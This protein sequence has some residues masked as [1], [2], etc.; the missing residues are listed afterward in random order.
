MS[1]PAVREGEVTIAD[2][3]PDPANARKH[4]PRNVGMI[5]RSLQEVGAARSI[6]IDEDGTVLAGNGV[7]EAAA[8]AGI[9]RVQI[10]DADGETIIA[11]RRSGLTPEQKRRLAL[12]DNRTAELAEW[13]AEALAGIVADDAAALEGLW[14]SDELVLL[15]T[16]PDAEDWR[17][18]MGGLP[19]KDRAPFRQMTFTVHDDQWAEIERALDVARGMGGGVSDVNENGNGNALAFV[20]GTF[21]TDHGVG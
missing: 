6:V 20:C 2:L 10:V 15:V 5:E 12:Y 7:L 16:T 3:S 18:A 8:S 17:N 14:T 9:E 19:D 1:D 4:S 11:V 13:D 21:V